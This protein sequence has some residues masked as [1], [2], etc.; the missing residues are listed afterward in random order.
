MFTI[1][2]IINVYFSTEV[3]NLKFLLCSIQSS[4]M[5]GNALYAP[6]FFCRSKLLQLRKLLT[7]IRTIL[8]SRLY[9][10][11]SEQP[12][13]ELN[14]TSIL[15][16]LVAVSNEGWGNSVIWAK[17]HNQYGNQEYNSLILTT[18][19]LSYY[20]RNT[21]SLNLILRKPDLTVLWLIL[22]HFTFCFF[23]AA[24]LF[25]Y[26]SDALCA[27]RNPQR[28][29][30][31]CLMVYDIAASKTSGCYRKHIFLQM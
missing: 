18:S 28:E 10:R 12:N 4:S 13:N 2:N 15:S 17:L 11:I 26:N 7:F 25:S 30:H 3:E 14:L 9:L 24:A 31:T 21:L 27:S 29:V 5:A 16:F 19:S 8:F 1:V 20:L 22:L 6:F 23:F